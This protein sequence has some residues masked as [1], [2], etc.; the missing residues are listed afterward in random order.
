MA[1]HKS[2]F[3]PTS[4]AGHIVTQAIAFVVFLVLPVVITLV[5]PL[6][7]VEFEKSNS[8]ATV[9]VHRYV[10]I[11]VPWQTTRIENVTRLR[12]DITAEK[13]YRGTAEERR[14][15]Q[16]GT[17]YAT[18][19]VAIVSNGPEV[20]LEAAPDLAKAIVAR[21]DHFVA[22]QVAAPVS[23]SV[24][25]SWSLSYVLGGVVTSLCALYVTG[26]VLAVLT[27][28]FKLMRSRK[29]ARV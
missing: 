17:S 28:P 18:G 11:F 29:R 6:T 23:I 20:K 4:L 3:A 19:R 21:F 2:T 26:V 1:T 12:A 8:A 15:G 24:Y 13:I 16:K 9:T 22:D 7:T 14:K 5:V 25:A 10:L 27:F